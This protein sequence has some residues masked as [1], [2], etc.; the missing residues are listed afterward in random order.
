MSVDGR[1]S[2]CSELLYRRAD[3]VSDVISRNFR[4]QRMID[5]WLQHGRR[6][7]DDGAVRCEFQGWLQERKNRIHQ[8]A[9][10]RLST[11]TCDNGLLVLIWSDNRGYLMQRLDEVERFVSRAGRN[12]AML[13]GTSVKQVP[14]RFD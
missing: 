5:Q 8:L 1:R 9:H 3:V 14:P 4:R 2:T 11:V 10:T 7:L 12:P 13:I 6:L